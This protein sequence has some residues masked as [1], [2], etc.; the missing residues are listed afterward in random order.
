MIPKTGKGVA[1]GIGMLNM[2]QVLQP[3]RAARRRGEGGGEGR[4]GVVPASA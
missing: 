4:G 1:V 3:D 2:A